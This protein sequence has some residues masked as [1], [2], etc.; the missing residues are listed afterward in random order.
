RAPLAA[1]FAAL[2]ALCLALLCL[3]AAAPVS[4]AV[5]PLV[6][7]TQ[8]LLA[9]P[10]RGEGCAAGASACRWSWLRLS[11]GPRANCRWRF[12]WPVG[13]TWC[14]PRFA[15]ALEAEEV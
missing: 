2:L 15:R 11:C 6:G 12:A 10:P 1:C 8:R 3:R 7:P 4:E 14:R 5:P 13:S 9:P